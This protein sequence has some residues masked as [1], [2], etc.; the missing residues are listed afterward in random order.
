MIE[1]TERVSAQGDV[2]V[3][4]EEDAVAAD[5]QGAGF[6]SGVRTPDQLDPGVVVDHP[7]RGQPEIVLLGLDRGLCI[8]AEDAVDRDRVSQRR[9]QAL[10]PV[11]H[12]VLRL[13]PGRRT[14]AGEE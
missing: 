3:P 14:S 9:D 13:V 7:G 8:R 1:A 11:H 10:Q 6:T 2:I 5:L 4:L 12:P